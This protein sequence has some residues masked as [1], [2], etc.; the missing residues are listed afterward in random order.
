MINLSLIQS[1]TKVPGELEGILDD[2]TF[3]K[4]RLYAL[5]K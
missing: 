4:A 3:N 2:E 5:D 1:H